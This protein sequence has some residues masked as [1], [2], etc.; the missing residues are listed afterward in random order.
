[1]NDEEKMSFMLVIPGKHWN[2]LAI[3]PTEF[4]VQP[5]VHE[6][7]AQVTTHSLRCQPI[8]LERKV[9]ILEALKYLILF[10]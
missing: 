2:S 3:L 7:A 1:M 4:L 9:T 6:L 10:S 5:W 8:H